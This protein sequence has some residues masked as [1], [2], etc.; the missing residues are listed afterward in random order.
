[1]QTVPGNVEMRFPVSKSLQLQGVSAPDRGQ[2]LPNPHIEACTW[3]PEYFSTP[4][5]TYRF[6]LSFTLAIIMGGVYQ[7]LGEGL[8]PPLKDLRTW[9]VIKW[10]NIQWT[11]KVWKTILCWSYALQIVIHIIGQLEFHFD[12]D[13]LLMAKS[14]DSALHCDQTGSKPPLSGLN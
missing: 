9:S 14:V 11:A 13:S 1:M 7:G 6:W 12:K 10:R 3:W 8:S 2:S 4:T 5:A